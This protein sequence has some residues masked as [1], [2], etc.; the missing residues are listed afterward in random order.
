[1]NGDHLDDLR[2]AVT[3]L[4]RAHRPGD[5]APA[6]P[7][8][9]TVWEAL[10]ELG[11]TSLTVP[12][13]LGGSGG[14]L[15]AAAVVV[16]AA[17][18]VPGPVAEAAFLAGPAL[19]AA[20]VALPPGPLTA[21]PGPGVATEH[22]GGRI[23][24]SGTLARVPWLRMCAHVAVVHRDGGTDR[25]SLVPT[26]DLAVEHGADLAGEP[27][28][29]AV[30]ERAEPAATAV[31]PD[32]WSGR[33]PLLGA[34]AR[35][36]Q[37]AGL[38]A[39][40]L[41]DTLRHA[42]EREQFGRPLVRFQAVQ[43]HI[44]RLAADAATADAAAGA[45]VLALANGDPDPVLAVAAAKAEASALAGRVAALAHQV[46]GALGCTR[47]HRLG[48]AT[49]RLW[50][51]REE[52]GNEHLWWDR[53]ARTVGDRDPWEAVTASALARSEQEEN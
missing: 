29:T 9:T 20:G 22:D 44:A 43:H 37:I 26:A 16:R 18:D 3:G 31:L 10:E 34:A 32:G 39:G 21:A 14:D 33:F 27:R 41:D 48:A 51:R 19:A 13:E 28:D 8:D 2:D 36:V 4:L 47:E 17:A 30:L 7:A 46:H 50:S 12:E 25:L 6:D 15:Y 53:V 23:L 1:M 11:F 40:V 52:F 24:L 42:G 35:T 45:A 5:S 38:V 49:A